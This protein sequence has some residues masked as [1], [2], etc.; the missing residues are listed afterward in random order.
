MGWLISSVRE[1]GRRTAALHDAIARHGIRLTFRAI[2][3]VAFDS[4]VTETDG[5]MSVG[6]NIVIMGDE[7]EGFALL[8]ELIEEAQ[9]LGT[10]GRIEIARGFVGQDHQRVVDEGAGDGDA[11]L[12]TTGK[13]EGFVVEA[14]LQS[15]EEGQARCDFATVLFRPVLVVERDLN[16]LKDCQLLDEIIGLKNKPE[17]SAANGRESIV[18]HA[19]DVFASQEI[20]PRSR[21]IEA[22]EQIE[23]GGFATAGRSHDADIIACLN[24]DGNSAERFDGDGT[25]LIGFDDAGEFDNRRGH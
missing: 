2:A 8:V 5:A 17:P 11:L 14:V 10:R 9:D 19:R 15:D 18:V 20:I 1:S 21:A 24:S 3:G 6:G 25:H 23:H 16:I 7:D 13:L 4:T 22:A 12:L